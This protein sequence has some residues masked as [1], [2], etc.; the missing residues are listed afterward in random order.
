[1]KTAIYTVGG[2]IEPIMT[3]L[4]RYRPGKVYFVASTMSARQIDDVL[5]GCS[6]HLESE[7]CVLEDEQDLG[8]CV[9]E[10]RELCR[11]HQEWIR[12]AESGQ[13]ML[14]F[15]GGTKVMVAAA[16]MVFSQMDVLFSYVGGVRRAKDGLGAVEAGSERFYFLANPMRPPCV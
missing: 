9:E 10:L 15:T 3:S 11:H 2:S 5:A 6:F 12:E 4:N 1:M 8:R 16:A 13:M 14:D 7:T